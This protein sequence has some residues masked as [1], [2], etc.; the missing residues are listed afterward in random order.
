MYASGYQSGQAVD[1]MF[2]GI[3]T[4]FDQE[5]GTLSVQEPANPANPA[6]TMRFFANVTGIKDIRSDNTRY[7]L[8][9]LFDAG[10]EGALFAFS[11]DEPSMSSMQ[12][13]P[14]GTAACAP[15]SYS[16][17]AKMWPNVPSGRVD[18]FRIAPNKAE[19]H[20]GD[21]DY[22]YP[23]THLGVC[24]ATRVLEPGTCYSSIDPSQKVDT[25]LCDGSPAP[26][27]EAKNCTACVEFET[28]AWTNCTA[29]CSGG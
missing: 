12:R 11:F 26:S 24:Q 3:I 1:F 19:R 5:T 2:S 10:P 28:T 20:L 18:Y 15:S 16:F 7:N 4:G 23:V 21:W 14:M 17:L 8:H 6:Q 22:C 25:I 13:D 9:H 27:Q 29:S